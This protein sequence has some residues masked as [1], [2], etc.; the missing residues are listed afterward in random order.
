MEDPRIL[1]ACRTSD[2]WQGGAQGPSPSLLFCPTD[3]IARL[4]YLPSFAPAMA[5]A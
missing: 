5:Q 1:A 4:P 3:R 2:R